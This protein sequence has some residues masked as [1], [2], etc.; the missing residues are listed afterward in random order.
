[1][2]GQDNAPLSADNWPTAVVNEYDEP[3]FPNGQVVISAG[4]GQKRIILNPKKEDQVWTF[5]EWPFVIVPHYLLPF[6]WQGT[7][8]VTLYKTSQDMINTSITHMVNNLKQFGDPRMAIEDGA[9]ALNPKTKKPWSISSAAGSVLRL[10]RGGLAKYKIEPPMPISPAA[11]GIYELFTQEFKNI[12]G[13]QAVAQG[14]Q[15]KGS[16]T[17]TEAQ[18]LAISANDRIFLQSVYE[19]EWVKGIA[20]H[21]AWNMQE[22]YDEGRWVRI[23]GQDKIEGIA[24]ITSREKTVKYDIRV[25]AGTTLPF[26]EEKRMAKYMEAYK[27]LESPTANPMLPELLRVM[28]IPNW[29]KILDELPSYQ[30]YRQFVGLYEQVKA[31]Q[32][33][34]QTA[35]QML[36][37]AAMQEY[38]SETGQMPQ[39]YV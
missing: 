6:M 12:T 35:I 27:L 23:V 5:K 3:V 33:D 20:C 7:N 21:I 29:K 17:A 14:Q 37:Q 38:A 31:G 1:L 28:E 16:T 36:T 2:Y 34:P 18:H 24:Q 39:G 8:A 15:L 25:E 26:D 32:V 30:K 10:M 9:I 11:A 22:Y 13:L 19:D 4:C